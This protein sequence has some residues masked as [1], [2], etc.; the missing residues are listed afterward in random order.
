MTNAEQARPEKEITL[1]GKRRKFVMNWNALLMLEKSLGKSAFRA[2]DWA[3]PGLNDVTHILWAGLLS[4]DPTLTIKQVVDMLSPTDLQQITSEIAAGTA[5]AMPQAEGGA[6]G[7]N[8][9]ATGE[10]TKT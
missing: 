10:K 7:K 4:E 9:Q 6:E 5:A 2:I 8:G 1:G 3:D